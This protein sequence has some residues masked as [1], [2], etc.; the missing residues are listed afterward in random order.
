MFGPP[1]FHTIS[2]RMIQSKALRKAGL[3]TYKRL[4]SD[5]CHNERCV[6]ADLPLQKSCCYSVSDT[7][8]FNKCAIIL[9]NLS[10]IVS[11]F[12]SPTISMRIMML[13]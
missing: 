9:C 7:E 2:S 4:L 10:V 1:L 13:A 6:V 11:D 5:L 8:F 12:G 3:F